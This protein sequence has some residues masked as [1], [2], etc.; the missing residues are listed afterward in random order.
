MPEPG[1]LANVIYGE[2]READEGPLT[3][4]EMEHTPARVFC[5]SLN[6]VNDDPYDT[7]G[8]WANRVSIIIARD[9]RFTYKDAVNYL[10][11]YTLIEDEKEEDSNGR[12]CKFVQLWHPR[13]GDFVL[14]LRLANPAESELTNRLAEILTEEGITIKTN[15]QVKK[16]YKA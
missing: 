6:E 11:P 12:I 7:E 3:D 10:S 4:E 2:N 8:V 5:L 15:V 14:R 9:L 16:A 1:N 13:N